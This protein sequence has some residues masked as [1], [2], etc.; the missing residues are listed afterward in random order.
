MIA[1][2]QHGGDRPCLHAPGADTWSYDD[3]LA[4]ANRI[5]HALVEDLGIVPGNRV[6][7]RGPNNQWLTACWFARAEDRGRRRHH[8]A[9]AATR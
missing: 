2:V 1:T 4:T 9:A 8:D 7:L 5:A 6:L 3:L